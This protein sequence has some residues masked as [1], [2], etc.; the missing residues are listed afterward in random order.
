MVREDCRTSIHSLIFLFHS[1]S[2]YSRYATVV[3]LADNFG[4]MQIF[5]INLLQ[6]KSSKFTRTTVDKNLVELMSILL[7]HVLA[8]KKDKTIGQRDVSILFLFW[9]PPRG[10]AATRRR[11]AAMSQRGR[12]A[13]A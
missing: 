3:A 6:L 2:L 13:A 1:S 11:G 4:N 7:P 12:G 10:D 5:N 9:P 8:Q